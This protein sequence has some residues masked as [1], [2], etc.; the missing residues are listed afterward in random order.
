ML[1]IAINSLTISM[2]IQEERKQQ[3]LT[4]TKLLAFV[5]AS[6]IL[7]VPVGTSF[8]ARPGFGNLYYN[9]TIVRTVVTPSS[10]PNEGLDNFYAVTNGAEG[11]LGIAAVAPGD[12]SYHGG[13]WKF[14]A[15]TFNEGVTPHLL[16]SEEAVLT[17]E[18]A[19]DVT[20]TR[21]PAN[22]F[23]CPIQP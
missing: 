12:T 7:A 1:T 11:Q 19:G 9:D 6:A 2:M 17:A 23:L 5:A 22:D 21:V 10:F 3:K 16:T 15:I 8:A 20:I 4:T 13:H 18:D 14:N